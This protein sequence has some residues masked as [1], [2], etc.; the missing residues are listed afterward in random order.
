MCLADWRSSWKYPAVILCVYGFF[1]STRPSEPYLTP[2]LV[3]PDKN[4]TTAEVNNQMFPVWTY[5]YLV[6]LFPVFLATDYLHY[7]PLVVLQGIAFIVTWLLLLF[8]QGIMAMQAVEF[9]FGLSSATEVARY[10]YIYSVVPSTKYQLV[11]GQCR[12]ATLI[13]YTAGSV[14]GQILVS[15]AGVSYLVLNIISMTCVSIAFLTSWESQ[16]I[17]AT[18][19]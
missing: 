11:T 8:A 10:S 17:S 7:K 9:A 1:C 2:Y 12:S 6:L 5:S 4:L 18:D 13:G 19:T 14:I 16:N 15:A 3:G